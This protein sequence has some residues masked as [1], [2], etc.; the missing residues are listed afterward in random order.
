MFPR[1]LSILFLLFLVYMATLYGEHP[2]APV[3]SPVAPSSPA[4]PAVQPDL[5]QLHALM[6]GARW[7]HAINPNYHPTSEACAA[8]TPAAGQLS[9]FAIVQTDGVGDA[10]ACGDPIR[11]SIVRWDAQH[12]GSAPADITLTLGKQ[13]GL[14]GMLV[15]MR[16]HEQRLVGVLVPA[17]GYAALPGWKKNSA[18]LA[19]FT[20]LPVVAGGKNGDK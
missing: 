2:S 10:A 18:Q 5:S 3:Q 20:Y 12:H 11:F 8:V 9:D 7:R 4:E 13:R 6:D 14:D 16:P 19:S 17:S 15:G 1:W